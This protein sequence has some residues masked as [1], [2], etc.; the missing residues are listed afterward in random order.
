MTQIEQADRLRTLLA[1]AT[2]GPWEVDTEQSEGEYGSAPDTHTGYEDFLIGAEINGKWATLLTTEN[3]TEKLI[4]EDYDEDYHRAWDMIGEANS[5][6]V[7]AAV[8]ALP[9]LLDR[10]EAQDATIARLTAELE[11]PKWQ[12]IE[13]APRDGT[14]FLAHFPLYGGKI[15]RARWDDDSCAK[16]PYPFFTCDSERTIGRNSLRANQPA[17][18]RLLPTPPSERPGR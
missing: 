12:P 4:D 17:H 5:A 14:W 8:N 18:W 9:S 16:K 15:Y 2:K 10:I 6:L 11:A 7:V 13:T 1:K 3:A